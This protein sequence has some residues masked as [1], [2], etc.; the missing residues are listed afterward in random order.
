M[1]IPNIQGEWRGDP[2]PHVTHIGPL[3]PMLSLALLQWMETQAPWN[4]RIASFYEQWEVHIDRTLLPPQLTA[5][6]DPDFVADLESIM[7]TPL[8]CEKLAL[9]ELTAHKLVAGQT[10]RIHND[11][12]ESGESHRLVIQFNRGWE[13]NQGGMLM[14]FASASAD[15]VRRVLRPFHGS[16]FAFPISPQSFHAV[17][18]IWSGERYSLV[19]SFRSGS[20]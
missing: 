9:T 1:T 20:R 10:I 17:S 7:F 13:D 5:V 4:P 18:T 11:Y 6:I 15:D 12:L 19:Y 16:A 2:Y 3:P 8:T 14:L